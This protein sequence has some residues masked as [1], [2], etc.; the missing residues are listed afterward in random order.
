M[1]LG[2]LAFNASISNDFRVVSRSENPARAP[3]LATA[4]LSRRETRL[5][6]ALS[7][8]DFMRQLTLYYRSQ[9]DRNLSRYHR[10]RV[11]R[12]TSVDSFR[13]QRTGMDHP[14]I[15]AARRRYL[16]TSAAKG[17]ACGAKS[18]SDHLCSS[19]RWAQPHPSSSERSC[20]SSRRSVCVNDDSSAASR[21]PA[22]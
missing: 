13:V 3:R 1:H 12:C 20:A 7:L 21:C 19:N 18:L 22:A 6:L 17:L 8:P 16:R 11:A 9:R 4:A 5:I 10:T 14:R 15:Y 2:V